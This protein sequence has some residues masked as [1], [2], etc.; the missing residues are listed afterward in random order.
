MSRFL[1]KG[2]QESTLRIGCLDADKLEKVLPPERGRSIFVRESFIGDSI[3]FVATAILM[4]ALSAMIASRLNIGA[5]RDLA[6]H[7][8]LDGKSAIL[9]QVSN[10]RFIAMVCEA[11]IVAALIAAA[12]LAFRRRIPYSLLAPSGQTGKTSRIDWIEAAVAA[13]VI[14]AGIVLAG[15]NLDLSMRADEATTALNFG[16]KSLWTALSDYRAPNNHVLHSLLVWVAHQTGGW[17]PVTLRLPAFLGACFALPATW[18]FVRNEYNPLAAAVATTLLSTSPLFI[19][20]ATNARGYSLLLLLFILLLIVGGTLTRRPD[21][22]PLW[23]LYALMIALGFLTV[24]LMVFPATIV[25]VW[26]LLVRWREGCTM[27]PFVTRMTIWSVVALAFTFVLYTPVLT[28]SGSEALFFNRDVQRNAWVDGDWQKVFTANIVNWLKW[29]WAT[30]AWAQVS[31]LALCVVGIMAP[32]SSTGQRSLFPLATLLGMAAVLS[33]KPVALNLRMTIFQMFAVLVT[34]GAGIAV[35][36]NAASARIGLDRYRVQRSAVLALVSLSIFCLFTWWTTRPG[37][38]AW[39]ASETGVSPN[40]NALCASAPHDLRAGDTV[41]A[42]WPTP[43]PLAFCLSASG[44]TLS[45]SAVDLGLP[46]M[47]RAFSVNGPK[48]DGRFFMFIDDVAYNASTPPTGQIPFLPFDGRMIRRHLKDNRY[49]YEVIAQVDGGEIY[50]V[51]PESEM[52]E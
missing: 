21:R 3:V 17:N 18:W 52:E 38:A 35:L 33:I 41:L 1:T 19:E 11:G 20:Y 36:V 25:V 7:L 6:D 14:L 34:A 32:R 39:F 23:A 50:R 46:Q 45:R 22:H 8:A 37:V 10:A 42:C 51:E 31:L 29:H 47:C 26:M 13:S 15:R 4:V 27:R 49:G 12:M 9:N 40:A 30:P 28:V 44:Y 2:P 48:E 43:S 5:L 16:T 24:P